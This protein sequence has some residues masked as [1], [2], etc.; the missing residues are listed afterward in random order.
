MN[1]L[2]PVATVLT[3]GFGMGL[4]HATEADHLAAVA[5]LV[6]RGASGMEAVRL[7][8]FWGMGHTLTLAALAGS[9]MALGQAIP[10]RLAAGLEL[11]VGC[12][13]VLLGLDC[14]RRL[15]QGHRPTSMLH[16]ARRSRLRAQD[17]AKGPLIH[18]DQEWRRALLVGMVHGLAGSAA[19][20]LLAVG[21]V[22]GAPW[23]GLGYVV[24]FGL[25]SVMGMAILAAT[26][27]MGLQLTAR[28]DARSSTVMALLMALFSCGL[29]AWTLC[30]IGLVEGLFH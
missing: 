13:L 27:G 3:L 17:A 20:L 5:T 4:R 16:R 14:L 2:V 1:D 22:A 10:L 28:R 15:L 6:A 21:S 8:A 23:I 26:I 25:G 30:R 9:M 19:L 7:G 29:G 12:M 24:V 18:I 11:V